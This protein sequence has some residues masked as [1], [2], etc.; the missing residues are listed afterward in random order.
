VEPEWIS[1]ESSAIAAVAYAGGDLYVRYTSGGAY[2]YAAVPR[3]RFEALLD[4]PSKGT[5]VNEMIKPF[6]VAR[7]V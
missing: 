3:H 2:A 6:Y 1:V 4:A 5:F 7:R